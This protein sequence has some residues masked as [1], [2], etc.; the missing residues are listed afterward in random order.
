MECT[1]PENKYGLGDMWILL[2]SEKRDR[3][4]GSGGGELTIIESPNVSNIDCVL[5]VIIIIV[6]DC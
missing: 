2:G 6:T 4:V 1:C 3:W 5:S